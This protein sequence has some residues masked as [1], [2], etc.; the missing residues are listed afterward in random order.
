M[1][2]RTSSSDIYAPVVERGP[3]SD[4]DLLRSFLLALGAGGRKEKTL[5]N[6]EAS[7]RMLSEFTRGLGL[8]GLATIDRNNVRH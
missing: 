7:I 8:P 6:Y 1:V 5:L 3:I 2:S 4:D